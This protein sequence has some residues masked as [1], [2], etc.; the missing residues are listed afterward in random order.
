MRAPRETRI[1][2]HRPPAPPGSGLFLGRWILAEGQGVFG[3]FPVGPGGP[4]FGCCGRILRG[5]AG[6]DDAGAGGGLVFLVAFV[7][8]AQNV[9]IRRRALKGVRFFAWT[10]RPGGA[11]SRRRALASGFQ[12]G[13]RI[14][15]AAGHDPVAGDRAAC[16]VIGHAEDALAANAARAMAD[17]GGGHRVLRP[18]GGAPRSDAGFHG[19]GWFRLLLLPILPVLLPPHAM[20]EPPHRPCGPRSRAA[21]QVKE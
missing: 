16:R 11:R 8:P 10:S 14:V 19:H 17:R 7:E 12:C 1:L 18:A 3:G 15:S 6:A 13:R 2:R 4:G 5:R 9:R 20:R 21:R